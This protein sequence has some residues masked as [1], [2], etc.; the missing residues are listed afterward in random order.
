M[1]GSRLL[2]ALVASGDII[3][4]RKLALSEKLFFGEETELFNF[5][6][7]HVQQYSV[8]PKPITLK[9]QFGELP[10]PIEP[11]GFYA[12]QVEHRFTHKRLNRMLTECND[13]MKEQDTWTAQNIIVEAISDVRST[14]ARTSMAEFSAEAHDIYMAQYHKKQTESEAEVKMGWPTVDSSG[15][16]RPGDVLSIIGRPAMGKTF[17]ILYS[18]TQVAYKQNLRPLVISLE[19]SLLEI[20]ERLVALYSHFPMDHIQTYGLTTAQQKKLPSILLKA[21]KEA[22]KLWVL[23]SNFASTVPDIFSLVYQLN[24]SVLYIDGAYLLQHDDRR[25]D[26]YRR[27]EA[28]MELIKRRAGEFGIPVVLSY[29]FNREAS[30]KQKKSKGKEKGGLEDIAFTDAVGQ[31]SSIVLG[32]FEEESVETMVS[33][34]IHVLK[35]RKGQVGKFRINWDF[36]TMSFEELVDD[37]NKQK[38][39]M[40]F[41]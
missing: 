22:G 34:E 26:R 8:L 38:G 7:S 1:A 25:L 5:I 19:M 24:P 28:N 27:A 21:K 23:D 11:I 3:Q 35:G 15:G 16:L 41:V 6:Q 17:S 12:D 9:E 2:C 4:Y 32:M 33:R 20:M 14:Q 40:Q 31:L 37:A 29:Q 39:V 36:L 10:I 18:A 13:L 30:K